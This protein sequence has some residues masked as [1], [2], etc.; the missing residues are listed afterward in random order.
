MSGNSVSP[1]CPCEST[2][3]VDWKRFIF[4]PFSRECEFLIPEWIDLF[5]HEA[6]D[7][8]KVVRELASISQWLVIVH[9]E[10]SI[11]SF[12]PRSVV[13][14][15]SVFREVLDSAFDP[16]VWYTC[17]KNNMRIVFT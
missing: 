5:Q 1:E 10:P 16:V 11:M 17:K 3:F 6:A 4:L 7:S 13:T 14:D 15:R 2:E 8:S 9:D 12:Q